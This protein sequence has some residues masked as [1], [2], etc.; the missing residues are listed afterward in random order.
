MKTNTLIKKIQINDL[1]VQSAIELLNQIKV[2][3]QHVAFTIKRLF[4]TI[5]A[6]LFE[7]DNINLKNQWEPDPESRITCLKFDISILIND[8]NLYLEEFGGKC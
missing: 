7:I 5:I 4:N 8:I 2:S 6:K 1:T 3:N